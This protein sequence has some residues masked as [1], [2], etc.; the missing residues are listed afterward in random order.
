MSGTASFFDPHRIDAAL[1]SY[2]RRP[3]ARGWWVSEK[4]RLYGLA[5]AAFQPAEPDAQ[6]MQEIHATL[7]GYWQI[8][9]NGEGWSAARIHRM[10]RSAPC[11]SCDRDA[12][13]LPAEHILHQPLLLIPGDDRREKDAL[14]ISGHHSASMARLNSEIAFPQK[15][16]RL[17]ASSISA[18]AMRT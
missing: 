15:I 6:A 13:N 12:L 17:A 8:F 3:K 18:W 1:A 10:L 14:R 9:R 16:A 4:A 2:A 7:R 5:A 11:L